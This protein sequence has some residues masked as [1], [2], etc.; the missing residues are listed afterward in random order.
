MHAL[1]D[2]NLRA[3]LERSNIALNIT[4]MNVSQLMHGGTAES[5]R[6]GS[7]L[8]FAETTNTTL[9]PLYK[10]YLAQTNFFNAIN[11]LIGA[12]DFANPA[13]PELERKLVTTAFLRT[14]QENIVYEPDFYLTRKTSATGTR[15]NTSTMNV[16]NSDDYDV[17]LKSLQ[18]R[19]AYLVQNEARTAEQ[20]TST[21]LE[22]ADWE[23]LF[24]RS[25]TEIRLNDYLKNRTFRPRYKDGELDTDTLALRYY[26]GY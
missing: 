23:L 15:L 7:D 16:R 24:A 17:G 21:M 20:V 12:R 3:F 1:G 26:V 11:I 4:R 22:E 25:R 14:H 6:S 9:T 13:L 18:R 2:W 19:M 10:L 5:T 8:L